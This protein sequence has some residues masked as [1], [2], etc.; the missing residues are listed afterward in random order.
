MM[1]STKNN[2]ATTIRPNLWV[3][4]SG[5]EGMEFV[6]RSS[7][8]EDD[9][10]RCMERFAKCW[11]ILRHC[12]DEGLDGLLRKVTKIE[13]RMPDIDVAINIS[14]VHAGL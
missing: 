5:N 10:V 4:P 6:K 2:D 12:S 8:S 11:N 9:Q 13:G 1:V 14:E 3:G 7:M